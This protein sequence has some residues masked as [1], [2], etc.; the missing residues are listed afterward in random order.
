MPLI[1]LWSSLTFSS[2]Q[3][4]SQAPAAALH[5]C[6]LDHHVSGWSSFFL[7]SLSLSSRRVC[8][9]WAVMSED[10]PPLLTSY[11]CLHPSSP[12]FGTGLCCLAQLN[13]RGESA[14]VRLRTS[15]KFLRLICLFPI[16]PQLATKL[17][18][19]LI[20]STSKIKFCISIRRKL[21]YPSP[22]ERGN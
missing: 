19:P 8:T 4:L 1:R 14:C 18:E 16:F 10:D 6:K 5:S 7:S 20:F 11:S 2:A 21:L 12:W 13:W 15:Q 3:E 17:D 9:G 22:S